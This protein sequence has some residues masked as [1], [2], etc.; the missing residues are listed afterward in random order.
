M[1]EFLV[2]VLAVIA[3]LALLTREPVS[4]AIS[5]ALDLSILTVLVLVVSG[6]IWL[7]L[8]A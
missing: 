3:F 6:L 7:I 1:L 8:Q 5:V 2:I 4:R